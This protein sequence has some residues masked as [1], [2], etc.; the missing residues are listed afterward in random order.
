M[1]VAVV[2]AACQGAVT[3]S[4]ST[5]AAPST[6]PPAGSP[7]P[8]GSVAVGS[9]PPQPDVLLGTTYTPETGKGGGTIVIGDWEETNQFHP[10]FVSHPTD[11]RVV[12]AAWATLV[13]QTADGRYV[14]DLAT[15]IPTTTNGGVRV[16][17]DG[18]DAMTVTWRLHEGRTWS[19]GHSLTCGDFKYAWEWVNDPTNVGVVAA[20]FEDIK[21]F[22]CTSE[23]DMIWHFDR[24]YADYLTLMTAP[25]PRHYLEPIPIDDQTAGVGFRASEV[26]K[27]PVSGPFKFESV[28]PGGEVRLVRNSAYVSWSTGKPAHLDR[29]IWRWYADADALIA[30]FSKGEVNLA[31]G[32][33]DSDLPK[34]QGLG[35]RVSTIP[36]LQYEALRPNWSATRCSRSPH[37]AGRGAGCPMSDPA[38]R[39]AL[40]LAIDKREIVAGPLGGTVEPAVVNVST[41]AW[42]FADQVPLPFDPARARSTLDAAGWLASADGIRAKAGLRAR[43]EICTTTDRA[44]QATLGLV[45]A[46]LNG[47]G[48]DAVATEVTPEEMFADESTATADTPCALSL[49]SFDI[50]LQT[51]ASPLDPLASFFAYHSSQ[52]SPNGANGAFVSDPTIDAALEAAQTSADFRVIKDALGEF[53]RLYVEK[54]VEVPLYVRRSV[55]LVGPKLG[56]Y[57]A[58]P[59]QAGP[60]WNAAD[61]F[62][63]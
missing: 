28:T 49:G 19:D 12:S 53:Q 27:M 10:Y 16:P 57:V 42:F 18:G 5:S 56:N 37:V 36:T 41:R 32:L 26:A 30:G 14:A 6:S 47:V 1:L 23:T 43:I 3:P 38:M 22:E 44:S 54:A 4:P 61:W 24:V 39:L 40:A 15:A 31:T 21:K 2:L 7:S 29:L 46:R 62:L 48:I 25:L 13:A 34:V 11:T 60:T 9:G 59:A 17:G 50:A 45:V 8:G 63:R 52:I 55:E 33:M 35:K 58:N 51:L 20:G